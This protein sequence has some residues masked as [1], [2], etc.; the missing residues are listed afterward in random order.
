M[1]S[2]SEVIAATRAPAT[3]ATLAQDLRTLGVVAGGVLMV[4]SSLSALGWV[5]GGPQAVVEALFDVVGPEGTVVMPTQS[6]Q[7]SDP[8]AWANP[9]VPEAWIE[10]LRAGLPA[11]DPYLTATRGMGEVVECFRRHPTAIR[12]GHPTLSFAASGPLAK[13]IIADHALTPALG[14]PSPLGRL[15]E[16]DAQ[17][18]LLG[19][20]H[21]H[22]TTLHL[23]EHRANWQGKATGPESGP[24]RRG[25]NREW[26]TYDDLL[27]DETDFAALGDAFAATITGHGGEVSGPVGAGT[28][29]LC[30]TRALVDFAV[31]WMNEHRPA[32]LG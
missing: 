15:Y 9:P 30:R 16:H 5:A 2:E 12:S 19:V 13:D 7:L 23:A 8:A 27:T 18:L 32:S 31:E 28:G 11:F 24:I 4:H 21:T 25:G 1:S 26:V 14:E 17:I 22:A 10:P 29:R 6:G 3:V 20:S